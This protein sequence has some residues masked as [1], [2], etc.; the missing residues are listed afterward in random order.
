MRFWPK[1]RWKQVLLVMF[2][3]IVIAVP[4]ALAY[5]GFVNREPAFKNGASS[6]SLA[7]SSPA[8]E[9]GTTIP[10]KYTAQGENINPPLNIEAIPD[11]TKS[12]VV[13]VT[14]PIIPPFFSWTHWVTWNIPP[15]GNITENT[16]VGVTGRNSWNR[17]EYGGPD[18][19]GTRT[20]VF[21][22][23]AI[24]DTLNLSEDSGQSTVFRAM[25]NHVLAKAQLMGTYSK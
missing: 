10:A 23:Y 12:L 16:D 25:D 18:P 3:A 5:M 21:T 13:T 6:A 14:D 1:K 2:I 8:F 22:V 17:P 20:Y 7:L 11:D 19:L 4:S 15:T 9:D 24:D